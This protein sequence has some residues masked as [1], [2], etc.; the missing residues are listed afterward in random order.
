MR[1]ST[2]MIR[3]VLLTLLVWTLSSTLG[4]EARAARYVKAVIA[5][6]GNIVLEGSTGDNGRPDTDEVWDY[7][8]T[9]R[10]KATEGFRALGV[11]DD[12][13]EVILTT[14]ALK[15][16]LGITHLGIVVNIRYGGK[17]MTR[18]LAVVRVPRDQHGREWRIDPAQVDELFD[19]RFIRRSDAARLKTPRSSKP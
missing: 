10:F 14:N 17:A 8:K 1:T 16:Q 13:K 18:Q 3:N 19:R 7:L 6:D 11:E 15:G 2:P 9:I 4:G 5:V 12:A